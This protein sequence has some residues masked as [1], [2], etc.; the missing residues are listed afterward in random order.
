MSDGGYFSYITKGRATSKDKDYKNMKEPLTCPRGDE[1]LCDD[2]D[3]VEPPPGWNELTD[4]EKKQ[5]LDTDMDHYWLGDRYPLTYK[6][7]FVLS[8]YL[9]TPIGISILF[10]NFITCICK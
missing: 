9:L 2:M 5:I 7:W 8:A 3:E 4:E 6:F 1:P 10:V